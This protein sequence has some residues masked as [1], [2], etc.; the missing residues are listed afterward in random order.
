MMSGK[1]KY[2]V[3]TWDMEKQDFTPQRGVR[4]GPYSQFGL[5]RPLRVLEAMGYDI[6]RS[7]APSVL[8]KRADFEYVGN[9]P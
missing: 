2:E 4:R 5:R 8:V 3:L 6:K 9:L 1:P 7:F